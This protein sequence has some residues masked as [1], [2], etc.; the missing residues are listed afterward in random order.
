MDESFRRRI[1]RLGFTEKEVE[2]YEAIIESGSTTAAEIAERTGISKRHVYN[3]TERLEDRELIIINNY[4]HPTTIEPARPEEVYETMKREANEIYEELESRYQSR[5]RREEFRVL[6]SKQTVMGRIQ[7]L[8]DRAEDTI[9]LSLPARVVADLRKSLEDAVDREVTVLLVLFESP[10][11]ADVTSNI[12][13]EGIGHVIKYREIDMPILMAVDRKFGLVSPRG[14]I[15]QPTSEVNAI[16]FGQPYLE[17][18][19]FR[20][21]MNVD[22]MIADEIYTTE[23]AALPHTYTNFRTAVIDAKLHM[24]DGVNLRI[25]T[26]VRLR[27]DP[28]EVRVLTGELTELK[29][30]LVAPIDDAH[31]DQCCMCLSIDGK[32]VTV[33]GKDAYLENYRAYSTT[34]DVLE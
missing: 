29:Q 10:A 21:L 2:A 26:K 32:D 12:D 34:L 18:V 23:P 13:L 28:A 17:S 25:E 22:W 8:I 1:E 3:I 16:F 24:K 30:R 15:T 27:E 20:S 4:F 5:T 9:A 7:Q 11:G 19:V 6:K 31:P 33:G 14:A